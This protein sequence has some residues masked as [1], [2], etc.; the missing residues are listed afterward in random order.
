MI[1]L[2]IKKLRQD[3]I[4]PK[5]NNEEEDIGMD[6]FTPYDVVIKKGER[7]LIKTGIAV[8]AEFKNKDIVLNDWFKLGYIIKDTSGNALKKGLFTHAGVVDQGYRGD[9]GVVLTNEGE[10]DLLI[11]R[12]D[13]IAQAIFIVSPKINSIA[14]VNELDETS[15]GENGWGSS[16]GVAGVPIS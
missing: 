9:L 12:G 14:E 2:K 13:K 16:S 8:Q 1:N 6:L 3:A 5:F 11:K 7:I 10:E 15:R 4:V